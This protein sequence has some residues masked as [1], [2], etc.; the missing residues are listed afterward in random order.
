MSVGKLK[1]FNSELIKTLYN[2]DPIFIKDLS[3]PT[4]YQSP[5]CA[6]EQLSVPNFEKVG[7]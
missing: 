5:L 4:Q 1:H 3:K 6:G 7:I 2:L